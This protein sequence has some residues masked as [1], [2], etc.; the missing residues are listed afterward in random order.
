ML[1]STRQP[2][3]RTTW[4]IPFTEI[5]LMFYVLMASL[6]MDDQF[7]AWCK[8][9]LHEIFHCLI[10]K[11]ARAK[12]P[13]ALFHKPLRAYSFSVVLHA[14]TISYLAV[15]KL[16]STTLLVPLHPVS[17]EPFH[18]KSYIETLNWNTMRLPVNRLLMFTG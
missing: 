10:F 15:T 1:I 7:L 5:S 9:M 13:V 3:D 14:Q 16:V 18:K 2:V 17:K 11:I 12:V 6:I 4:R 8:T